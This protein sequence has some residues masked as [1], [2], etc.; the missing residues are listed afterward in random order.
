MLSLLSAR[1]WQKKRQLAKLTKPQYR[2]LFD[3][4]ISNEWVSL[5]CEMTGTNPKTCHLLSVAAVRIIK[6]NNTLMIDTQNA[7]SFICKPPVMPTADSIVI[8]GLRPIDV[9]KGMDYE[10]MLE[11]LL[12]FIGNRPIVGFCVD[13]DMA[14]INGIAKPYLGTHLPNQILDVSLIEQSFAQQKIKT[15]ELIAPRKHLNELIDIFQL[16]RLPAHDALNDAVMTAMVFCH[17]IGQTQ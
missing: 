16:P 9:A 12:P 11:Q 6:N 17:L 3:T 1:L 4:T 14:F 13:M 7:L 8:H 15:P 2:Y 10:V 5:D